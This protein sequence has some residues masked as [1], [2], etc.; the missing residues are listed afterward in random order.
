M[1]RHVREYRLHQRL[2]GEV[3]LKHA[4]MPCVMQRV[5][6]ARPHQAG[7]RDRAVLPRPLHHL[8]DGADARALVAN[9]R[10]VSSNE[11]D[12]GRRVGAVA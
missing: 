9:A 1:Q 11:L 2:V 3:S 5:G 4:A 7:G 6:Q 8:D 12:F 10:G